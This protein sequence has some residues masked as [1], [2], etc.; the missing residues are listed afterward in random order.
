MKNIA[1]INTKP[2]LEKFADTPFFDEVKRIAENTPSSAS[3]EI[4]VVEDF[5]RAVDKT[6][7]A[8]LLNAVLERC[9]SLIHAV[10]P[11]YITGLVTDFDEQP[12]RFLCAEDAVDRLTKEYRDADVALGEFLEGFDI[13]GNLEDVESIVFELRHRVDGW[14]AKQELARGIYGV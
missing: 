10:S 12:T 2:L 4:I 14:P 3:G 1:V 11:I 9:T 8:D 7:N 5:Y 6:G 13:N